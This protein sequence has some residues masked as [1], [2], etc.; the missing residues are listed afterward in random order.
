VSGPG[1]IT[2]AFVN[3]G[4]VVP[5]AGTLNIPAAW[6]NGGVVELNGPASN[7]VGGTITNAGTI[8]GDGTVGSAV[9]NSGGSIEAFGGTL[10]LG[11]TLTN[12]AT[13]AIYA[14]AGSKVLVS[15]GLAANAGVVN[16]TGG[17][18]DNSGYPL[19]NTGEISGWGAFRT[20]G[21][22][23]SGTM[24]FSGGQTTVNGNVTNNSRL[25]VAQNA[26]FFSG[27]L[28]DNVGSVL[29]LTNATL[30]VSGTFVDNGTD[31]SDP[32]T[33]SFADLVIGASGSL[34]GGAGDVY[35]VSGDVVS[36]STQA[37]GFNISAARL[38]LQGAGTHTFTWA[39]A[40][41]G[42]TSAGYTNNF[43]IGVFE[44]QS[45]G[46]VDIIDGNGAGA[47]GIYVQTLELDGGL[48]QIGSI[49]GNGADIF[50]DASEAGNAYLDD[51]SY[52]L[53]DGGYL[54]PIQ[55]VPEP[56]AA[57]LLLFGAGLLAPRLRRK[58]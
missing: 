36:T 21:L 38:T 2:A 8:Q 29:N 10:V 43:A 34:V 19:T 57:G 44:I 7:I 49:T 50:Y 27:N 3:S 9:T 20:G 53:E 28:T 40:N 11:G 55:P 42:A 47:L 25:T 41:L 37:A 46:A 26:A 35:N 32:S 13:G 58:R 52:A 23:N 16:L 22:T 31:I 30:T 14:G 12:P 33:Q 17:T 15:T 18:F 6:T 5:N 39:G 48:S 54:M 51:G 24:T 4:V 56:G 1:T 45:G